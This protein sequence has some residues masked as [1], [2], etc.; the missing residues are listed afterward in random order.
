MPGDNA[1]FKMEDHKITELAGYQ[2]H[3]EWWSRPYEYAWVADQ[4]EHRPA[5][6][7]ADMGTGWMLRP[8]VL[9]LGRVCTK[10]YAVD[11]DERAKLLPVFANTEV[12][13]SDF[14]Q[15]VPGIDDSSLDAVVCISVLEDVTDLVGTLAEFSRVL[16]PHGRALI[17]F[18]T[19][20]DLSKA[21]PVYPG[22]EIVKF[23]R[24]LAMTDLVMDGALN[25]NGGGNV[26]HHGLWNLAS[27]HCILR[28]KDG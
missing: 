26:V 24:A 17:T 12:I 10:V 11:R 20:Y 16:A 6:V 2:L 14:S 21:C 15:A 3:P 22:L 13:V 1:I 18:D 19:P 5:A 4:L 27:F 25:L 28:H 23:I 8:M 9:H 7:V